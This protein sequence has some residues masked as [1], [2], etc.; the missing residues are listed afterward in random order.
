M[1]KTR[2]IIFLLLVS[3]IFTANTFNVFSYDKLVLPYYIKIGLFFDRTAK[4]SLLLESDTTFEVGIFSEDEFINLFN[5][6]E[7]KILLRKDKFYIDENLDLN[8]YIANTN[9]KESYMEDCF[10]IQIGEDFTDYIE[11]YHFLNSVDIE[12]IKTYLCYEGGWK[13]YGGLYTNEF[14]ASEESNNININYGYNTKII[15]PSGK[16]VQVVDK[17]GNIIFMYDSSDEIYFAGKHNNIPLV[18][19]EGIDYRGGI[20]AKRLF[21]SDMTI[22]NKLP[23]EE[24]L[25]GVIPSEVFA[26]WPMEALKAQAVAARGFAVT[27]LNKYKKFNFN[28]CT[29]TYSQVYKG[30]SGEHPNTN[31]AVDE[32]KDLVITYDGKLIEPYYHSNSG[33]HTEDS[34]NV[35]TNPLPYI[36]GVKDD[37]SLDAPYST[38]SASFTKE[39]IKECLA[40]NNIFI[41]DILDMKASVS[42]NG[43]VLSLAIYGTKGQETLEKERSRL[44]FGL[45]SN[46]FTVNSSNAE[47]IDNSSD[48]YTELVVLSGIDPKPRAINLE[49]KYII[50]NNGI[51][52]IKNMGEILIYDGRQYKNINKKEATRGSI[53][54][55]SSPNEFIF[56]G[57]G[58]GHGLGM[59]QYGAKKMAELGYKYDEILKHY[60]TGVEVE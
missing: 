54:R 11:A 39:E 36:R 35:W 58:Y 59:S 33:G 49:G 41:G 48:G 31:K 34:E 45:R 29:T 19:V 23:L 3:V 5:L 51:H 18:N 7:N 56:D 60:Y 40:S 25:Y 38:W 27:N 32:T 9:E 52:E 8:G 17:K 4:S 53:R 30:Y 24:Y 43:R 21:N 10:H 44:V 13:I 14:D 1:K 46:Q 16:R 55:P 20:T 12:D 57:K 15:N 6:D 26:S 28:L 22:I 37:F 47:S 2:I 50:N 42:N